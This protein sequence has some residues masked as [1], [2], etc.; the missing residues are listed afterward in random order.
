MEYVERE[1]VAKRNMLREKKTDYEVLMD[2][3]YF[4]KYGDYLYKRL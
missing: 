4:N 1:V 3:R 2:A